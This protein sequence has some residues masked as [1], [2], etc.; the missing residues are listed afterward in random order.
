M[1]KIL[2]ASTALVAFAGAAAAEVTVTGAAEMGIIGGNRYG[3]AAND[4]GVTQFFTDVDVTFTMSGEADNG[5][6]FGTK[7]KFEEAQNGIATQE[8]DDFAVWVA[9]GNARLD[10]GD[11]DGAFDWAMQE[12]NLA[13]G[14][15]DDSETE[16]PGFNAN[17]GF[18]GR[19]DGQIARFTYTFGDFAAALSAEIDDDPNAQ[20]IAPSVDPDS[21]DDVVWGLG[22]KYSGDL[23]GTKVNVG[24]GYQDQNDFGSLIGLSVDTTLASGFKIGASYSELDYE[25]S[26]ADNQTHAAIGIGYEMNAL[27]VGL[28]YGKY[29]NVGGVDGAEA[30]GYGLAVAYDLGG[31]LA[32]QFGYGNGEDAAGDDW[33]SFSLGLAMSF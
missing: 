7:V 19:E 31:G 28:N 26:G 2:F 3:T 13:A 11:T 4:D 10:M 8:E 32:V 22:F 6:T 24:L 16:H 12:M 17:S 29:D 9:Y 21:D 1:K 14:S 20:P 33:D 23:A 18:D 15:I 5:L 27:S 25:A 30:D